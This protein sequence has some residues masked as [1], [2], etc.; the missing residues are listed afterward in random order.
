LGL[1]KDQPS[2]DHSFSRHANLFENVGTL[3]DAHLGDETFAA[4]EQVLISCSCAQRLQR[5]EA[6]QTQL[7]DA[8]PSGPL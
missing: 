3:L 2:D 7:G 1:K 5:K 4:N 6:F 8:I